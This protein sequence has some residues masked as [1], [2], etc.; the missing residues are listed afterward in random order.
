MTTMTTARIN[1]LDAF[2]VL[3]TAASDDGGQVRVVAEAEIGPEGATGAY[4][5]WADDGGMS[6][7]VP[8]DHAHTYRLSA[9]GASLVRVDDGGGNPRYLGLAEAQAWGEEI[10]ADWTADR[11]EWRQERD[12][13]DCF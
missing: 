5:V 13:S 9:E 1:T 2:L 10:L 12:A 4:M 11:D 7:Y 3:A 8:P 6:G